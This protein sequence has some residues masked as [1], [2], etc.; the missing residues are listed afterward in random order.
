MTPAETIYMLALSAIAKDENLKCECGYAPY[1]DG[2][3]CPKCT[4]ASA[5]FRV[6]ELKGKTVRHRRKKGKRGR[7]LGDLIATQR[8]DRDDRHFRFEY[9]IGK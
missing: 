1:V 6:E 7:K 5:L 9:A 2:E 8:A 3:E 4:A